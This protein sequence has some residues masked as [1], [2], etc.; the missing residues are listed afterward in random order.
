MLNNRNLFLIL[1]AGKSKIK[2]LA[3]QLSKALLLV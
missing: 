3:R 1:E 2:V